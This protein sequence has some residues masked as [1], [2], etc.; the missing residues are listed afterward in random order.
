MA[1]LVV[2]G[3]CLNATNAPDYYFSTVPPQINGNFLHSF[4]FDS[5]NGW[6][7]QI[8]DQTTGQLI[9]SS[10]AVLPS[11]PSCNEAQAF[12][13]GATLGLAVACGMA[14]VSVWA[15]LRRGA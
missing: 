13:D 12:L 15:V 7:F 11:L 9:S 3:L 8:T 2:N 4:A 5:L 6:Q 14:A 10:N 1:G